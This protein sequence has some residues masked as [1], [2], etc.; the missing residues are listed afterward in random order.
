[1]TRADYS[2]HLQRHNDYNRR[3]YQLMHAEALQGDGVVISMT[4]RFRTTE[5]GQPVVALKSYIMSPF[6]DQQ[7]VQAVI[8]SIERARQQ[9]R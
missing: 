5:Y 8:H 7:Y 2:E 6:S 1:Q 9:L 3:L 4:D